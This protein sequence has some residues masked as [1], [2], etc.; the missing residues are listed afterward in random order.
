[1]SVNFSGWTGS[2]YSG[3]FMNQGT[4]DYAKSKGINDITAPVGA[5]DLQALEN[6][7]SDI[8]QKGVDGANSNNLQDAL[9]QDRFKNDPTAER[10]AILTLCNPDL[11]NKLDGEDHNSIWTDGDMKRVIQDLRNNECT[12]HQDD[13]PKTNNPPSN[14]DD[15]VRDE[16]RNAGLLNNDPSVKF[17]D[18][19]EAAIKGD[20][21]DGGATNGKFGEL[22]IW[23]LAKLKDHPELLDPNQSDDDLLKGIDNFMNDPA[24]SANVPTDSIKHGLAKDEL[25]QII[26][27]F[28][29]SGQ[30][31][32]PTT[33]SN[34]ASSLSNDLTNNST[35]KTLLFGDDSAA[36]IDDLYSLSFMDKAGR[37]I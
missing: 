26:K 22:G 28:R 17:M 33:W 14:T 27:E 13:P 25:A 9:M 1:M 4:K 30:P 8:T 37:Y 5:D 29:S 24:M 15:A 31:G 19:F 3:A 23:G 36:S 20:K 2:T 34:A 11:L 21:L 35:G 18:A 32:E 10:A 7:W 12:K 6:H 16:C